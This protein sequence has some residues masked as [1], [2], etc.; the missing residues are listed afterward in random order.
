MVS[1]FDTKCIWAPFPGSAQS[2]RQ[3]CQLKNIFLMQL[4]DLSLVKDLIG[5]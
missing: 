3:L 4:F 5:F 2:W 1:L